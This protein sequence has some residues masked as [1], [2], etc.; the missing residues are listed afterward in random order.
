MG[1]RFRPTL[2]EVPGSATLILEVSRDPYA[3][4]YSGIGYQTE[5]VR[6]LPLAPKA[7]MPF[8]LPSA[9]TAKDGRYPL[10]RTL[11]LYV[12]KQAGDRKSPAVSEFLKFINSREGQDAV[13]RA[14]VYPL[15]PTQLQENNALLKRSTITAANPSKK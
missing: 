3:I 12:N 5:S 4:G 9:E 11:Y 1:W 13:V 6:V 8:V 2:K 14:G 7:G 10:V 15:P